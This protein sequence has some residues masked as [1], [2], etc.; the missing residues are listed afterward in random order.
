MQPLRGP[1]IPRHTYSTRTADGDPSYYAPIHSPDLPTQSTPLH[2]SRSASPQLLPQDLITRRE[3]FPKTIIHL[4]QANKHFLIR[5]SKPL[6]HAWQSPL[7]QS[8]PPSCWCPSPPG[9]MYLSVPASVSLVDRYWLRL[10]GGGAEGAARDDPLRTRTVVKCRR[11]RW[12]RNQGT[13]RRPR[14]GGRRRGGPAERNHPKLH[15]PRVRVSK[16]GGR[17]GMDTSQQSP[18]H[19]YSKSVG[20]TSP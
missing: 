3:P 14:R 10:G 16:D 12:S 15:L 20:G 2:P 11:R 1:H 17:W 9:A 18:P 4:V 13:R 6:F 19:C 8:H 7:L 5:T